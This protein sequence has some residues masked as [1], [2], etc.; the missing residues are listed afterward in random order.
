MND[1]RE[2]PDPDALLLQQADSHRGKLKIYFGACA[3]VGKTY[4]M[5]QEAQRLRAQGLDVL[6]GVVETHGREET[7]S[8]LRGLPELPRRA[9]GRSRHAEFDLD[10]ALARHP[11]VILMDEL[12]HTNVQ[13]SRHPKRWQ[14][15]DELLDA[16]I[17]V[18]TTVNV[19][20]LESLN[21]VVGGVTGIRVR[22]TLPDPFFDSA[23]EIVLVDLPPDDLRQ[24][25]K[26]GKVYVGDRAERAIENFFRKGNLFALRELAL[27]RTA[28]R[29]DD[30]MRAW[31]DQQGRD[32]VWHTRDAILLC[33]GDDTGSEK[34]VRTAARLAARLGSEWHAVYVETP[35][36]NRLPEAR[37]RAILKT[38][39]LAQELGAETATLSD[40]DE[41]Q[42]VLR[43]AREHNLGKIV[44]GRRP[45]RRW[46]RDSFAT[47]LGKLG[48]DLDLLVVALDEPVGEAPA[49]A[50]A[51]VTGDRWRLPLRGVLMALLL[52]IVVTAAG[53]W[54]LAGFDTANGVMIYLL[55]VVIIA[56]RYGRWPSVIATV[57]N[58][59]AFDLFFVAPTGT[60]A[61]SDLQYLVTFAVMLAVGVIVGNLTAGVRYQARVARY[62]EQRARHLYEMAKS[63]GSALTS[64]DIAATSQRVI[65][66]TLQ[67]RSLLLLP[68]EQGELV[69]TGAATPGSE[70]DRAIARWSYSKGQ[71]AGAGTDTLPAVPYQI[72]PLKSGAHCRGLLV[73]EPQNL[74]QLMIPEQQRLV[75]TFTVLIANALERMAL[76]QS[77]A[78]SRLA[79]EREQL[80]N[81]LLSAL[82][83]DL[84]TP[85]TVLFGQAEMLMLDLA[86]EESKYVTQANQIREQTLSTIRLVSNMLDMARIQSGGLNLRE[87]WLALDEVI[88]GAL[89]SMAPSLKG[90]GVTLDLPSELVLI[91][92]DS[93]LLERVLTNLIENSLKYAGNSAQRGIRAWR[94]GERLEVAVWDNGP[95]IADKDLTRIFDKFA[96]GDKESSVPGVGLGL[97]I[98]KTIVESHG[99]RIWAENR[100]EGGVAFR[101]SLPLPPAPEIS[102]E[103]LK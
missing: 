97:A 95:G 50:D 51:R 7:A 87:E 38:L 96:R 80:R 60:V 65:E 83:H 41:A 72:L 71:P 69:A 28:D 44:T 81:A 70:P 13:G 99:G 64:E 100:I 84:R 36:L 18:I 79:A 24:R 94:D 93:A 39:Q 92:G 54:L 2:R 20:H 40:P 27:R 42:A 77:E 45:L 68:D 3:G 73:V 78:A 5:L 6:I 55:A 66:V 21:D 59:L 63:L 85:L 15:I 89:S 74:R 19:Q 26:E 82:S 75:E 91:K 32:R 37:R 101:L 33:I 12:A 88:G 31:R 90:H 62:R 58:I 57:M 25:L 22:E 98:C 56:L 8:L 34:L 35:R 1:E 16:G 14:D 53:R 48:P 76:S 103:A 52:C 10:A 46:H 43:Y 61:V 49:L 67:A 102:E 9:T 23:D 29:V 86:S 17:D 4:A 11:A 47:R 30:Q